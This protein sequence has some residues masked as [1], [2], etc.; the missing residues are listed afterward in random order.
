MTTIH[1]TLAPPPAPG[2]TS[3]AIFRSS[4]GL[5][6]LALLAYSW[7]GTEMSLTRLVDSGPHMAAFLDRMFPP[8]LTWNSDEPRPFTPPLRLAGQ[9]VIVTLQ[10]S[11]L[12]TALG[13][14]AA[15]G[16][17]FL[18]S[19]NLTPHWVHHPIKVF[20]AL[21]RSIPVLLLALL[22]VMA[23]GFGALPGVLALAI[24]SI[25][26][27][28]KLFGEECEGVETGVW[29]AMDSAGANWFQKVRYAIWPQVA[30]QI[31]SL[32]LFRLEMNLRESAVLG[33]VGVAGLGLWIENYRRAFDYPSVAT[34]VIVTMLV[35]L[36]VDQVSL[37][38]RRRLR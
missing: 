9:A 15:L 24:H 35:V 2:R 32:T 28:G 37:H 10:I 27:L 36:V 13:M 29:E 20:L 1:T 3:R 19:E 18:G 7:F 12:G 30:A 23:V 22:F 33:L 4:V 11:I 14:V 25:G 17:G 31:Y 6:V 38:I 16:L 8:D 26:M 5:I 34:L 21:L